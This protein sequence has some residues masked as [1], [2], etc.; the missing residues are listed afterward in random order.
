MAHADPLKCREAILESSA[1]FV[2]E[3]IKAR[4][5]CEKRIVKGKLAP[6]SCPDAKTAANIAEAADELRTAIA[7]ACGGKNKRCDVTPRRRDMED[8][9]SDI[10]FPA[11]CPNLENSSDPN[12]S[13]AIGNCAD[14]ATCLICVDE[15]AV[16]QAIRLYYGA[17]NLPSGDE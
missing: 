10:G 12:C 14:I 15:N 7:T 2:R 3:T 5:K 6:G 16:D 9:P 13:V 4:Q 17:L 8:A 11:T 1:S